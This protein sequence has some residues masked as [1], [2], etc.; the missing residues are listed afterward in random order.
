MTET[1]HPRKCENWL[2]D[3][4][5]WTIPR[6]EAKESY[7]FWTGLFTLSCVLRRHVKVGKEYLGSW[8]CYPYLYL[9]FIGP[10]GNR[11]TTTVNYNLDL[12]SDIP[13]IQGAPDQIT[14]PK[15]ASELKEAEE[16][17]MYIN[18]GE[19][20]EFIVKSGTD[21]YSFLTK[22]FDGQ[23]TLSVGTHMRGVELAEKPCINFLGASTLETLT[24]ILPQA[25]LDGG[26]GRRCIFIYEE[27]VRRKKMLYKDTDVTGIYNAHYNNLIDDLKFI[28]NNLFGDF[29]FTE[30]AEKK[31]EEWYQD[32]AGMKKQKNSRILHKLKGYYETKPAFV[33]KVAMLLKIADRNI[34]HPDQLILDWTSLEEAITMVEG[35]EESLNVILG[36]IGKNI[37]KTDSKHILKFIYEN[38]PVKMTTILQEFQSVAEPSK[39][40]ELIQGL[41]NAGLIILEPSGTDILVKV[42]G[43]K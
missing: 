19:L 7:I 23:K 41:S 42:V 32:G 20:N 28:S 37:Y 18:A 38:S 40:G 21:M 10:A 24:E 12:L 33:M 15:L 17:A 22:A 11:K 43:K 14:V 4:L 25:V 13:G 5:K 35:T 26:F 9:L 16:C 39:L 3:F 27:E 8:E 29:K 36:D 6:S 1:E 34:I 2:V 30:E 31:F